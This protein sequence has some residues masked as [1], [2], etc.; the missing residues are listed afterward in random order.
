V[1]DQQHLQRR[2]GFT[3]VELLVTMAIVS[4]LV[5]LLLPAIQASRETARRGQC[6]SNIKQIALALI[7]HHDTYRAFPQGGWGHEW[8]GDPDLG[9]GPRQPGG[10]IYNILPYIEERDLHDLGAGLTGAAATD[11]YSQRMRTPIPLLVCPSR[12]SCTTW[13]IG[14]TYTWVRTPKPYGDVTTVARADYAINGGTSSV[15]NYTGP[16]TL[17]QGQDPDFWFKTAPLPRGFNGISHLRSSAAMKSI[18]D[19]VAKT[20]LLGEKFLEPANYETGLSS[21]DNESLYAGYCSDLHRF[22]GAIENLK[23]S[24]SPYV[25]PL[26]DTSTPNT[27]MPTSARFGSSHPGGFNMA[28]CDGSVHFIP[29][30]VDVEVHFRSGHR[31]D[32][33]APIDSL[34]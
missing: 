3:L 7:V 23:F 30:D 5:A 24:L 20:Y 12:R 34:K 2:F 14:P 8:V 6:Q 26:S 27:G 25:A 17:A 15:T 11:L 21:G 18:T 10:W 1:S 9:V 22:A 13:P 32:N 33:G 29:F 16:A 31:S 4:L 28:F 19:G